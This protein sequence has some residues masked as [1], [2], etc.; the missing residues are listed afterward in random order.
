MLFV[1]FLFF[2][3]GQQKLLEMVIVVPHL[4][5]VMNEFL[6]KFRLIGNHNVLLVV[7][8]EQKQ[9][10]RAREEGQND[11]AVEGER[12]MTRREQ[13]EK[14]EGRKVVCTCSSTSCPV[15]ASIH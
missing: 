4:V 11:G 13:G 8:E 3:F 9:K 10:K 14:E 2:V 6:N 5:K 15:E 12:E 7:C 1:P